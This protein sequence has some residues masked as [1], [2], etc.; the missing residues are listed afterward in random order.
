MSLAILTPIQTL[1]PVLRLS[2]LR[3][4]GPGIVDSVDNINIDVGLKF[5]CPDDVERV[6]PITL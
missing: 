1:M 2:L 5:E 6:V 3:F 4:G